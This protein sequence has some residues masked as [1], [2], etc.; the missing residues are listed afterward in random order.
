[1]NE[2]RRNYP[3]LEEEL[4]RAYVILS[5]AGF[6][7]HIE[8]GQMTVWHSVGAIENDAEE[9]LVIVDDDY[10]EEYEERQEELYE[11]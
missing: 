5:D 8:D 1:M 4:F 3:Q 7:I 6:D 11:L 2:L 10:R 9:G